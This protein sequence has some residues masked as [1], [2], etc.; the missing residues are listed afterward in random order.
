MIT[1]SN[2][3]TDYVY[4]KAQ[5][6]AWERTI[7]PKFSKGALVQAAPPIPVLASDALI[8]D[9]TKKTWTQR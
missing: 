5:S 1:V 7:I 2:F 9:V 8:A 3:V 4:S 6:H